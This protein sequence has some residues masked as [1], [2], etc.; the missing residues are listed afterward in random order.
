[1]PRPDEYDDYDEPAA[2]PDHTGVPFPAG[3][4]AAGII[5]IG[6]GVLGLLGAATL[7]VFMLAWAGGAG[8]APAF[9]APVCLTLFALV[10]LLAGIETVKGKAKGILGNAVG[11]IIFGALYL[12]QSAMYLTR[13][14]G[15]RTAETLLSAA[16][17][18]V[19]GLA[20]VTAG[21]LALVG[22]GAYEKWRSAHGMDWGSR[23][24]RRRTQEEQDFDDEDRPRRRPPRRDYHEDDD[25]R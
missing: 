25:R 4:K 2:G 24:S 14:G 13:W 23:R 8:P 17:L 5:W 19:L 20:L 7:F 18:A 1:M 22:K 11:S 6:F 3:V 12:G 9:C 15:P 10:F 16:L 21:I